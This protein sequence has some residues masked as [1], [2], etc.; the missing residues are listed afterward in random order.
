MPK[1]AT[2]L[3]LP[4]YQAE[5]MTSSG[6][7]FRKRNFDELEGATNKNKR[8]RKSRSGRKKS[9]RKSSKS[10]SSRPRRAAAQNALSWFSKITGTSKDAEEEEDISELSESSESE[11]TTE[12]SGTGDSELDVA[13][14]NGHDK[15]SKGK[16]IL[17]CDSDNGAQQCDVSETQ[18]AERRRLVVRFPVKSSDKLS[19]LENLPGTSSYAP[20]PTLGNGCAEDSRVS[21]NFEVSTNHLD[22]SK[23]KWGM[24]KARTSKRMRTE[25]MSSHGLMGSEPDG[26]ENNLSK[27]ADHHDNG[28]TAPNCLELRTDIDGIAVDTDTVISNGL[29]NGEERCLRVDGSP[30]RV[31]DEGASNCSQDVTGRLHD[32]KDSLPP[33]S[34]TLRIRSKRVS[35]APDTSLKQEVKSSSIN[36]ENGGSDALND[37]SANTKLDLA[38]DNQKDGLVGTELPLT[39]DCVHESK[40]LT[41][42]PVSVDV[43][44][45][46]PKRMFDYV[47]RRKKSRKQENN[48]DRGATLTQET[49][50]GSCSQDQS[51]GANTHEGVPNGLHETES[52]GLE[53]PE[54]SL[55]H[56]RDKLSDSHGNQNSQ[57][58]CISTSGATLRS[59][60]T[61]NRKSTYPFS[62]SKPV[63]TK[64][65]Q[66]SIE[67]VSW[68]T[69]S[70]HEEGSRYIPQKGDEVAYLRQVILSV[71]LV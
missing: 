53:K 8:T 47:Y 1:D 67:K 5:I 18:P 41:S 59:R 34:R 31:A 60:S 46:H 55:T 69:L 54:S 10:K 38:L 19:L 9:K 26:E 40:P 35:R 12:D 66:Q 14:V 48:S 37:G 22:A 51:S 27:E 11:S 45:S 44:V 50:P 25:S 62:E 15:Q 24:V 58:E 68:L 20:T 17:V 28:V 13:L 63:E 30:S 6:R 39:N 29:P 57:E 16:D 3:F 4:L 70:T 23:V 2:Y 33:I 65:L 7:R 61:R 43:P 56:I 49:S 32:L 64:K 42:D 21:G 71:S 36:Q 52:N